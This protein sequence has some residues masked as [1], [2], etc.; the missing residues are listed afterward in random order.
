[1]STGLIACLSVRLGR[2][3]ETCMDVLQFRDVWR[4]YAW[5]NGYGI[6]EQDSIKE[7]DRY[8]HTATCRF[9]S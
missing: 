2:D 6:H 3:L 1:M 5:R 7:V 8:L 9:G 4:Y